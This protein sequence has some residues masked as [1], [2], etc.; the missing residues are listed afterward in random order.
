M[1]DHS[2]DREEYRRGFDEIDAA[3]PEP[4]QPAWIKRDLEVLS[5][6]DALLWTTA[7]LWQPASLSTARCFRAGRTSTPESPPA[8]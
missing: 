4:L 1:P 7:C 5:Q 8:R 2:K 6:L 3:V